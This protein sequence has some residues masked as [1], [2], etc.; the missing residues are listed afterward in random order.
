MQPGSLQGIYYKSRL[1]FPT[2]SEY[3][4]GP[5]S[6]SQMG[7]VCRQTFRRRIR[8]TGWG[9]A[10]EHVSY[11]AMTSVLRNVLQTCCSTISSERGGLQKVTLPETAITLQKVLIMQNNPRTPKNVST[12]CNFHIFIELKVHLIIPCTEILWMWVKEDEAPRQCWKAENVD[13]LK[14][15]ARIFF[16]CHC[17][18]QKSGKKKTSVN[19]DQA[20]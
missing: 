20:N 13:L 15:C 9:P 8:E 12:T 4:G 1:K 3:L 7:L 6:H 14:C 16:C 10:C 5:L 19:I 17:Y 11:W 18:Y 2:E